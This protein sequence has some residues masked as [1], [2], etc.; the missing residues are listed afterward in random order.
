MFIIYFLWFWVLLLALCSQSGTTSVFYER[1][2]L[3]VS[4]YYRLYFFL[5][6][7]DFCFV[8]GCAFICSLILNGVTSFWVQGREFVSEAICG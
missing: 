3:V 1:H 7:V 5:V 8:S 2:R 4:C 6:L